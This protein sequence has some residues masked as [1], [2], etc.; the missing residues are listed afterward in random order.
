MAKMIWIFAWLAVGLWSLMCWAAF[1][2][3][4]VAA[5]VAAGSSSIVTSL[6][7]GSED[8]V[9]MLIGLADDV[10]EAILA[11]IWLG[12]GGLILAGA[13]LLTAFIGGDRRPAMPPPQWTQNA[14]P[15][16]YDATIVEPHNPAPAPAADDVLARLARRGVRTA[17]IS[18]PPARGKSR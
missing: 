13:W 18:L 10:G 6:V 9:A 8:L 16:V 17:P 7:P 12:F 11:I 2:L 15:P 1:G 14:P 4:D 3:I 5:G